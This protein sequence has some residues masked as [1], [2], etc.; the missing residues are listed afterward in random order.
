MQHNKGHLPTIPD[1][2]WPLKRSDMT[3]KAS[4]KGPKTTI[5]LEVGDCRWPIGDP[6][7]ADFHYCGAQQV[8]GKPYCKEHVES[9]SE[10][11]KPRQQ[12]APPMPFPHR[13]AA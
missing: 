2:G 10:A 9:A 3:E 11:V 12:S 6:R 13:R 7:H 5:D 8:L 1:T 4:K